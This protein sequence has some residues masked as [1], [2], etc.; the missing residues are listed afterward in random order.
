MNI[1]KS[2]FLKNIYV[3]FMI[4][5]Q[6]V[7]LNKYL[8][9]GACFCF[10]IVE[11]YFYRMYRKAETKRLL[12]IDINSLENIVRIESDSP[13]N[14]LIANVTFFTDKEKITYP[15]LVDTGCNA[16]ISLHSE[17]IKKL[18]LPYNGE[19]TVVSSVMGKATVKNYKGSVTIGKMTASNVII[20]ECRHTGDQSEYMGLIGLDLISHYGLSIKKVGNKFVYSFGDNMNKN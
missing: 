7:I 8:V 17:I 19:T 14:N 12:G 9:I 3:L 10:I 18:N 6:V 4:A 13:I 20:S 5:I 15:M 16:G 2:N 11:I 1:I